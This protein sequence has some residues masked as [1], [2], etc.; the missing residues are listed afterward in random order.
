MSDSF[1]ALWVEEKVGNL[2]HRLISAL[3]LNRPGARTEGM[4]PE[5]ITVV[6]REAEEWAAFN[7]ST[8]LLDHRRLTRA[9]GIV[10]TL[11]AFGAMAVVLGRDTVEALLARQ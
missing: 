11:A 7:D 3:Q 9:A 5:L 6:T 1:L 2:G 8:S 10:L 4:S